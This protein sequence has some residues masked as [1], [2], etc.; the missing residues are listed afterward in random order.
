MRVLILS[1]I[2]AN[3]VALETV[4][5]DAAGRFDAIWCLG[6]VVGYGP[7]PNECVRFVQEQAHLCVMGNHDRAAL[8][9]AGLDIDYFNP[10]A[11]Q[12]ILWTQRQLSK[13]NQDFLDRLPAEPHE[14][15][16][17]G[18]VLI[19]HASPREPVSEYVQTPAIALE[20]F[21]CFQNQ[22]CLVGHTH[23]PAIYRWRLRDSET[24]SIATVDLLIPQEGDCVQLERSD[25]ERLIL[26]PGS[27]GQPRDN[28]PRA[29][30]ALLDLDA[31]TWEQRRVV[32][33]LELT[34]SQMRQADLPR[35]LIDRLHFGY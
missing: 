28:D 3:F 8:G 29:A 30:Y 2:H 24:P 22:I 5:A 7:A 11:R 31:F 32:Y 4:M 26:N 17:V 14:P 23:I 1:D 9:R 19:T 33:P 21:A 20:N 10:L 18:S 34:Q 13:E 25:Q 16:G 27:V 35:R 15:Q 6:D 12:A